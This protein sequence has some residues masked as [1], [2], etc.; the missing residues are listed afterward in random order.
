MTNGPVVDDG[1]Q[2]RAEELLNGH[3]PAGPFRGNKYSSFEGG[4][5][6]PVIVSWKNKVA[7]NQ[8]SDVLLSQIDWLAS[9]AHLV[10]AR[11]P[12]GSAFDR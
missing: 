5:A 10:G 3:S 9:F 2:D 6:V 11:L 4:T 8:E 7:K 1:Y 12:K